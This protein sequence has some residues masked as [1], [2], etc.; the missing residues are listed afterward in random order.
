MDDP[1]SDD[2]MPLKRIEP[3][4]TIQYALCVMIPASS[5]Y[6]RYTHHTTYDPTRTR[7]IGGIDSMMLPCLLRGLRASFLATNVASKCPIPCYR[8][9]EGRFLS[10]SRRTPASGRRKP[11]AANPTAYAT[12]F[13]DPD[14]YHRGIVKF[15]AAIRNSPSSQSEQR[16]RQATKTKLGTSANEWKP[17]ADHLQDL[18]DHKLVIPTSTWV[19]VIGISPVGSLESTIEGIDKH[20][21]MAEAQGMVD[22]DHQWKEGEPIP[23]L[24]PMAMLEQR[25]KWI[26]RARLLLS[27]SARPRGWLLQFDNRSIVYALLS[28]ESRIF[29]AHRQVHLHECPEEPSSEDETDSVPVID[30]PSMFLDPS[31]GD[32][33]IRIER[34]PAQ[35]SIPSLFNFLS[36]FDIHSI[37]SWK[38]RAADGYTPRP[39]Y[40]VQCHDASWARAI[41]REKQN[42]SLRLRNDS[43]N[44]VPLLLVQYPRQLW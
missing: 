17:L 41:V 25:L 28:T 44:P 18:S 21:N 42:D 32:H 7:K 2:G 6:G 12:A 23:F 34:V 33:T 24:P 20:L 16:R 10:T 40:I 22:L 8:V 35:V 38:K 39:T 26:R 1:G 9:H 30:D 31:I 36:R 5:P 13:F 14:E 3:Y 29:F 15:R 11:K 43:S 27:P 37:D 4:N 19:K